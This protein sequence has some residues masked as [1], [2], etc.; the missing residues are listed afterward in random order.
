M[1]SKKYQQDASRYA[2]SDGDMRGDSRIKPELYGFFLFFCALLLLVSLLSYDA[3]DP[4]MNHVVRGV[5]NIHNWAGLFGAYLSGFL[6]DFFGFG[7]Y[8]PFVLLCITAGRLCVRRPAWAWWRWCAFILMLLCMSVG[9][10]AWGIGLGEVRHGGL[11]GGILFNASVHVFSNIGSTLIWGFVFMLMLQ[12]LFG[13]SWPQLARSLALHLKEAMEDLERSSNSPAGTGHDF[14][15]DAASYYED[16]P[17][18]GTHEGAFTPSGS[19]YQGTARA[20][21]PAGS[22]SFP[23][24]AHGAAETSPL[25]AQRVEIHSPADDYEAHYAGDQYADERD[26]DDRYSGGYDEPYNDRTDAGAYSVDNFPAEH[27]PD[28]HTVGSKAASGFSLK[29]MF[30]FLGAGKSSGSSSNGSSG[31]ANGG[32]ADRNEQVA[33]V[34]TSKKSTAKLPAIGSLDGDEENLP[35]IFSSSMR[36]VHEDDENFEENS[37]GCTSE[38]AAFMPDNHLGGSQNTTPAS[39]ISGGAGSAHSQLA[40]AVNNAST[41]SNVQAQQLIAPQVPEQASQ[42]HAQPKAQPS[43]QTVA[44]H[45][46]QAQGSHAASSSTTTAPAEAHRAEAPVAAPEIV[47]PVTAPATS[48]APSTKSSE[49]APVA[50]QRQRAKLPPL[51]LLS[52]SKSVADKA[53]R[54]VLEAKGQALMNCLKD[55]SIQAELVRITP[56]PVVT[57]FEIRPAPGVK[58]SKIAG[59]SDDLAMSLKAV[60]VRI[61]APIPGTDT[62][63]IEVPN[64]KRETVD[65]RELLA[66]PLFRREESL[67]TLALGKDSSGIPQ[68]ADLAKMPHMLV[69]GAT[70]AGKSVF[71]N[72]VLLSFLYKARPDEVRLLLVDPKR[73][74]MAVYADIPHLVHP[75]VTDMA[76]AKSALEWA[77]AEMDRR[78]QDIGRLGVRNVASYNAKL[79]EMGANRPAE[80]HDLAPM[81]YLVVIIDELAD[82]MLTAGKDVETSIVRLAQL[83][84]AA[85][86]HLIIATQRPSVDIITGL[87]KA[88]FPCRISFQVTSKHDSR[89][90]LDTVGAEHLLGLGDMLFKPAGGRFKRMHGAFVSDDDVAAVAD[91]W[92]RQQKPDYRVDFSEWASEAEAAGSSSGSGAGAS[93]AD[94][95]RDEMY[96][97]AVEFVRQQGKAS[98]SLIQRRFRI[99]FNKAARFIEQMEEDGIIGPADGSKP[100]IVR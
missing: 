61:Q 39:N 84:R 25:A 5:Q 83:A 77:V 60:A 76:L 88:N 13:F 4:S 95:D 58:S 82:L 96:Y 81:P 70:G 89:T 54:E 53:S 73:I 72:S 30:G 6:V 79:A 29:K 75:I 59:L 93:N 67:L 14:A 28:S 69:A 35:P 31:Y 66:S 3:R 41:A 43:A 17:Q 64:D 46:E 7:A 51:D 86:I 22:A 80:L 56:G 19:L 23:S 100:R 27:I 10:A 34:K 55:F 20:D 21:M 68:T 12:L 40:P 52:P 44:P 9:G 78:Y 90:I 38:T 74:E 8:M 48:A 49:P 65:L 71:I 15:D 92:R 94:K 91:Y 32:S 36:Y 85:G 2:N 62:I 97:E 37:A 1:D 24:T 26:S 57:T 87:I 50:G 11:C 16:Y 47:C 63:G 42:A 98:I 45:F 33:N 18:R 99:G